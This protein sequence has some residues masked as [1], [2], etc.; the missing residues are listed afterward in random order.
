MK[1]FIR[2]K[3]CRFFIV[4]FIIILFAEIFIFNYKTFI[5]NPLNTSKYRRASYTLENATITGLTHTP[6]SDLYTVTSSEPTI[7]F[8]VNA[9][10]QTMFLD[11]SPV[12]EDG[13]ELEISIKYATE[14]YKDFKTSPK[15][16][17]IVSSVPS[18]KYVTCSYFGDVTQIKVTLNSDISTQYYIGNMEINK[19][20]PLHFSLLR[21]LF[22]LLL[23]CL[24]YTFLRYPVFDRPFN[25]KIHSHR[26]FTIFVIAI[27]LLFIISV[28]TI[29][30]GN[31]QWFGNT[32][33]NQLT[34]ELVDAFEH[35]QVHLM[36]PVPDKLLNLENPY[37]LSERSNANISYK[38]DHLLFEGKYY[39]YYGIAPVITL[40]LPYHM[41]TGHYFSSSLACLIYTLLGSLFIG[42][43]FISIIKNWF[44]KTPFKV[45]LMGL[46]VTLFASCAVINVMSPQFY[47][48]AQSSAL[49][50]FAIGFYFMINSGIFMKRNIRLSYLFLSALFTSLSVLSRATCA[51][52]AM[53]MVVWCIY[54][55][56]QYREK[57]KNHSMAMVKYIFAALT[58]YVIFAIIQMTYNYLRF[59]NPFDF[60][61]EYT[62]TIYDFYNIDF[63]F[64]MVMISLINYFLAVPV[65]NTQF[66]FIHSN[67]DNLAVNGYYFIAT[68]PTLGIIP[69]TP[70]VLSFFY[71]PKLTKLFASKDKIKF[72]FIWFLPGIV[73]PVIFAAMTWQYG[74]AM[75]YIADFGW[76][77]STAAFVVIFFVYNRLKNTTIKKWL[78]RLL[79][80]STVWSVLCY[81]SVVLNTTPME[82]I[83]HSIHGSYIYYYLRNL[84][85]FWC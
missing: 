42:L 55:F 5:I 41:I 14:S 83:N 73:F 60:G 36:D 64:S 12:T 8:S 26:Y 10:V 82:A 63:H 38:W 37:D 31:S 6:G 25:L 28:Y 77:M 29:Y 4:S 39:S 9:P 61:I 70:T 69:I 68:V 33:G 21:V 48:I 34:Q 51:L 11:I 62:L 1:I 44:S 72:F 74:Y 76:E 54:G 56:F 81:I 47:E 24:I 71:S 65:I 80:I 32:S 18:S 78:V 84:I 58:P 13:K 40:F 50:F 2:E 79:F 17:S 75:R 23:S 45:A 67:F 52:Y 30:V 22:L 59:K 3:L 15:S 43:C 35:G 66:P 16:F 49:C 19:A 46:I 57:N 20:I 85:A 27:S 53:I 7:T